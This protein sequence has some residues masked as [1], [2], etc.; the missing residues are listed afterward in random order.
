MKPITPL[1]AFALVAGPALAQ[2]PAPAPEAAPELPPLAQELLDKFPNLV[3]LQWK[4]DFAFETLGD[5]GEKATGTIHALWQDKK[6]F[7]VEFDV[8]AQANGQSQDV[9]G[10]LLADG[11]YLWFKSP[12][13]AQQM[14]SDTV[15]VELAIFEEVDTAAMGF[16][17]D[18]SEALE[19]GLDTKAM[20]GKALQ[21]CTITEKEGTPEMRCFTVD[22]GD[23]GAPPIELAFDPESYFPLRVQVQENDGAGVTIETKSFAILEEVP[24]G[25]FQMQGGENAMDLTGMLRMQMQQMGGGAA[26]DED[27]EF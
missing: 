17:G 13:L 4:A 16:P 12:L 14:G 10:T 19:G 24:E 25:A 22:V 5:N 27:L 2:D 26:E 15:K 6:H 9:S 21:G 7:K 23:E 8:A 18:V 11:T 1:V 3:E 20:L